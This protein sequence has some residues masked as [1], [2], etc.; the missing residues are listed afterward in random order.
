LSVKIF[1]KDETN[2]QN[3]TDNDDEPRQG[4]LGPGCSRVYVRL[5]GLDF[6]SVML[7]IT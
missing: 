5:S 1:L 6:A 2:A 3:D 7:I 4:N